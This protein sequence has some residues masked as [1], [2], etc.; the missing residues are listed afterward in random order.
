MNG[1]KN[2]DNLMLVSISTEP[3]FSERSNLAYY[4]S[5]MVDNRVFLYLIYGKCDKCRAE[6]CESGV[7]KEGKEDLCQC[8]LN[9]LSGQAMCGRNCAIPV[10][11][12]YTAL[13]RV[14]LER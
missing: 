11:I 8:T 9:E 12:D 6:A 7:V 4:L 14:M 2:P 5:T 1:L 13:A 10:E 3:Q